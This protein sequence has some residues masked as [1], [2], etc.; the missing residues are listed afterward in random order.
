MC[1]CCLPPGSQWDKVEN[2]TSVVVYGAGG[3]VVLWLASTIVGALNNI[4]LVGA[5]AAPGTLP[6]R[7]AG[8]PTPRPTCGTEAC[9]R[10]AACWTG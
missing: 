5:A 1:V 9:L 2:K 6:A 8:S 7:R 10:S 3:I 4:P